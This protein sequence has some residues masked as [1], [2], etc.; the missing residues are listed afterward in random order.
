MH[1][2]QS[3]NRIHHYNFSIP[4][5]AYYDQT[6]AG[7]AAA[8]VLLLAISNFKSSRNEKNVNPIC[9]TCE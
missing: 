5:P 4:I 3:F 7:T 1:W 8:L 2:N 6:E 9:S